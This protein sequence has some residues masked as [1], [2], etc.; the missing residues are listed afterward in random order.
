MERNLIMSVAARGFRKRIG[1]LGRVMADT[2][3]LPRPLRRT[4]RPARQVAK[5]QAQ[6]VIW[7][8]ACC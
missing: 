1:E 4:R 2:E 5:L 3:I 8:R 6:A 7:L